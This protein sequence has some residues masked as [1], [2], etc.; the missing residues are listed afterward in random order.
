MSKPPNILFLYSDQH[1]A[2]AMSCAGHPLVRTPHLDRLAQEGVR[3]DNAYCSTPLCAPQRVSMLTG[4]WAHNTGILSNRG[5]LGNDEPTFAQALRAAGYY[6]SFIGK[7]HLAQPALA[8]L[9]E[10]ERWLDA[11]GFDYHDAQHGKVFAA[12]HPIDDSYRCYLRAKGLLERFHEDYEARHR[13]PRSPWYAQPSVLPEEDFHDQYISRV[14]NQW[15][16][17]YDGDKPFFCWCNWGGPHAPWDAPG[18]YAEM[19]QPAN[20]D[21]PYDDPMTAAPAALRQARQRRAR[22]TPKD[23]WRACKAQYYGLI[24]LVDD[25]V[26]LMLATLAERGLLENT[27]IVY[28][29]DHGEMLFDHGLSG[30]SVM[31]EQATRVPLIVR[32]PAKFPAGQTVAAPRSAL[33]L[34]PTFLE[35]AGADPLPV[36]HGTSLTATPVG[37]GADVFCEM[38]AVKMVRR[39]QWKYVYQPIREEAQLFDLRQDRRE[40]INLAGTPGCAEIEAKLRQRLLQWLVET[41]ERPA[42]NA[43]RPTPTTRDTA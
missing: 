28:A 12:L 19:Y 5:Q 14:T 1:R 38:G 17:D 8:G 34:V 29:S 3:F 10:C 21:A 7:L 43:E 26:G 4:R 25:G 41:E 33:D 31:Y 2:D 42:S 37:D 15:L 16:A 6:T 39:R 24:S 35:L 27:L 20:M 36:C 23:A 11:A 32:W 40:L 18:K 9:P 13:G 30:K 22:R